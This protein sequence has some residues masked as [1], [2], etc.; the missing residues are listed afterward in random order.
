VL[1]KEKETRGSSRKPALCLNI[2]LGS[3]LE[4]VGLS[5]LTRLLS[6]FFLFVRVIFSVMDYWEFILML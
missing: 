2:L 1:E 4:R 3:A 5:W 6:V